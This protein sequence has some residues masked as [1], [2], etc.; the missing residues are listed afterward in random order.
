LYIDGE[1]LIELEATDPDGDP[2]ALDILYSMD[3]GETWHPL[4]MGLTGNQFEWD[5]T[6]VPPGEEYLIRIIASDGVNSVEVTSDATFTVVEGAPPP[7]LPMTTM[8]IVVVA[9][10]AIVIIALYFKKKKKE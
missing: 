4:I 3:E 5:L 9:V 1:C 8:I 7:P 10:A 6:P 2:V